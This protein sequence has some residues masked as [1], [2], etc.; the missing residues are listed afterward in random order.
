M[1]L[2]WA[3]NIL[4]KNSNFKKLRQSFVDERAL[5]TT[6]LIFSC[7]WETL[8][9]SCLRKKRHENVFLTLTVNYGKIVQQKKIMPLE[10]KVNWQF[11]DIWC[12]LLIAYFDWKIGVFQQTVVSVYYILDMTS[13][14]LAF[15]AIRHLQAELCI[16]Q[17]IFLRYSCLYYRSMVYIIS[18]VIHI[19]CRTMKF[20]KF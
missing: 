6:T 12:Y 13:N 20:M 16:Q 2:I 14:I 15:L 3:P 11:N 1:R 9:P 7:H 5:I 18:V 19:F 17:G 4:A 10:T 8:V